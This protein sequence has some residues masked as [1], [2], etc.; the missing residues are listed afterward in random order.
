M[1]ILRIRQAEIA[2]QDGRLEDAFQQAIAPEI[3]AHRRGQ[4]LA[5]N[6]VNRLVDRA[7]QHLNANRIS[8]AAKDVDRAF[9][10]GGN[11]EKIVELQNRINQQL[12]QKM[13]ADRDRQ[14]QLHAARQLAGRGD[15]SGVQN[16]V[17]QVADDSPTVVAL[18]RDVQLKN[19]ELEQVI[20][21]CQNAIDRGA[22]DDALIAMQAALRINSNHSQVIQIRDQ[23]IRALLDQAQA[24]L[25][26]GRLDRANE[27]ARSLEPFAASSSAI[28]EL[29]RIVQQCQF[30]AATLQNWR[31][32]ELSASL[33]KLALLL[34]DSPWLQQAI[35]Q[36]D[37]LETALAALRKSPLGLVSPCE[38]PLANSDAEPIL[39]TAVDRQP[40]SRTK[41]TLQIDG[42]GTV[43][44]LPN[45]SV[46]FGPI[47]T[48]RPADVPLL[49]PP[50]ANRFRIQRQEEDYFLHSDRPMRI[51]E[52][53]QSAKLLSHGDRLLPHQ[54]CALRFLVP[55]P[56]STSAVVDLTA[57]RMERRDIRRIVLMDDSLVIG[58]NGAAHVQHKDVGQQI[59]FFWKQ[60]SLYVRTIS[61]AAH[62]ATLVSLD[63]PMERQGVTFV[64]KQAV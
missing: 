19:R 28:R 48:S 11:Q 55:C 23:I 40:V 52:T 13:A 59:I 30:A 31:N 50:D 16:M 8:E 33:Q 21:R 35:V 39:A 51:N 36:G 5:T 63:S 26:S 37:A 7:N 38:R 15:F 14:G 57:A 29:G 10:L 56:A 34:P 18:K 42:Y 46:T 12:A 58:P 64:V 43:L 20:V 4:R 41:F 54:R 3:Q 61:G 9:R 1:L 2:L 22:F 24:D 62:D 27:T 60:N 53:D 17:A 32:Q 25:R 6:V 49:A 47:S 44:V 45:D